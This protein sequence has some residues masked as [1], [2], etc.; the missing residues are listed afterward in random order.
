M[1]PPWQT[2]PWATGKKVTWLAASHSP[3]CLPSGEQTDWPGA[4]QL[5]LLVL[6]SAGGGALG[7]VEAAG[8]AGTVLT[9]AEEAGAGGAI[10]GTEG[11]AAGADGAREAAGK[12]AGAAP[13]L[14]PL[15]LPVLLDAEVPVPQEPTGATAGKVVSF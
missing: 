2:V 6:P 10:A 8:A 5:P 4:V 11:A 3:I 1:Y 14:E 12:G 7:A 15:V 13:E 9:D